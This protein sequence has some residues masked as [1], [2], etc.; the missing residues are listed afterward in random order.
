VD[1]HELFMTVVRGIGVYIL[2]L[3]VVRVTGKRTIGNFSAFDLLV[4]LMLGEVVD[5]II[6]G[7]VTFAQGAVAIGVVTGLKSLTAWLNYRYEWLDKFL[8]G[9]PTLIVKDGE[10]QRRGMRAECMNEKDV[11]A[12]LRLAGIDD[13]TQVHLAFVETDGEISVIRHEWAENIRKRD[14]GKGLKEGQDLPERPT[15]PQVA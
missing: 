11:L 15:F 8:E 9:E 10:F 14:I 7:D 4:A 5:E 2:M 6:Y 13:M 3:A 12:T 1:F